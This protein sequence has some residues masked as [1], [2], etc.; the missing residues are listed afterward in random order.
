MRNLINQKQQPAPWRRLLPLFFIIFID[1]F[2]YF[3]IIPVLLR[4][5]ISTHSPLLPEQLSMS[6]RDWYYSLALALSP[7]AFILASPLIGH[8]SDKYGRKKILG[9][10][11]ITALIGFLLPIIGI[12]T[13][14]VSLIFIG[15]FVAGVSSSSQPVAQ[16][17]IA[18]FTSGKRKAY[19]LSYIAFAMTLAMVLGPLAGGYLSDPNSVS[20]F[21]SKTPYWAGAI[22]AV[23]NILLL[24]VYFQDKKPSITLQQSKTFQ[25]NLQKIFTMLGHQRIIV[26]L[27][28][29]FF[30]EMSWSQYYQSIFLYLS[31]HF[32]YSPNK[33]SIFTAYIG[34]WMC[35]GLTVIYK[36]LI[37]RMSVENFLY[38]SLIIAAIGLL[39]CCVAD[40]TVSEWVFII[41]TA[42][43]TGTAYTSIITLLSNSTDTAHQGLALGMASTVL[44]IAW[45]MTG[46]ATGWFINEFMQLPLIISASSMILAAI[47]LRLC[48]TPITQAIH[49]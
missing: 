3:L 24:I 17:A 16:A 18:D 44:G 40:S 43:F 30:L 25:N 37:R 34:F 48:L 46:A 35:L 45:M 21:N 9:L 13:R 6:M 36:I 49:D 32:K 47:M 4:I 29:L 31:H 39:G 20:W 5:F 42:I 14:N 28:T 23:L 2:S 22:L 41:P 26:L 15:R 19:Y 33:I 7:L 27:M 38:T 1:S 12:A 10:G 8:L 11:L